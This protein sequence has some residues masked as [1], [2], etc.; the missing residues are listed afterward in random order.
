MS[1]P[2][3]GHVL[4]FAS[5]RG[6]HSLVLA[7]RFHVLA[8]DRDADALTPLAAHPRIDICICDLESDAAW[9]FASKKFDAVL[10]TNYLFRPK[11]AALF[12][13]VAD[14]GYLAYETFAVG[15]AA[16]GRPK[17]PDFLLHEG[18]LAAALPAGFDILDAFQG[19]ISDPRSAVIQRLAARRINPSQPISKPTV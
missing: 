14:G 3:H 7:E 4:D 5:G 10:V 17:N 19:V 6:R 11:L 12:D 2:T 15:N 13:L 16:F 8:V 9:P 18:E 1:W